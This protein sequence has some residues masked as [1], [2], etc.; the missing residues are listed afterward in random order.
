METE[1]IASEE[2]SRCQQNS[3][4]RGLTSAVREGEIKL[5]HPPTSPFLVLPLLLLPHAATIRWR[6]LPCHF[7][8]TKRTPALPHRTTGDQVSSP[9]PRGSRDL[10]ESVNCET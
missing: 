9:L 6:G 7:P 1:N 4:R 3:H 8:R 10:P 2:T 5:Q